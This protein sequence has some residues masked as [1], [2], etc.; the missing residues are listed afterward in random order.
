VQEREREWGVTVLEANGVL[1]GGDAWASATFPMRDATKSSVYRNEVTEAA[2]AA[3][4]EALEGIRCGRRPRAAAGPQRRGRE[5]PPMR[6]VD[7]TIDWTSDDT[8]TVLRKI[9]AAD[10]MPGV[11]DSVLGVDCMLHGAHVAPSWSPGGHAPGAAVSTCRGAILRATRDGG[12]WITH[13][14]R[15]E[16]AHGAAIKLPACEV[17]GEV[18]ARLPGHA[19]ASSGP[20]HPLRYE[21][22]GAVGIVHFAFHNG[23][24]SADDCDALHA[25]LAAARQR[26]TR[27]LVLAGGPDYWSNGL[28]LNR[29][30]ASAHPAD[31]S[32]DNI[33][34]MNRVV[35]AIVDVDDRLTIAAMQGSA[36]AGGVFLALAADR[37][38][39]RE[40]AVL[41]AHYRAM[42]N[43]YGSEYWTYLLPRR[44]GA[45]RAADLVASRLPITGA[46][47]ARIG[48]ADAAFGATPADFLQRTLAR[49]HALAASADVEA[50]LAAKRLRRAADEAVKPL[51]R[52][53]DEE[54]AR[55][56][57]NFRGFDPS[58][59]VA[60]HHFVCKLPKARTPSFLAR[61]RAP[62]PVLRARH[63]T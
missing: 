57:L 59:H 12:V 26:P 25:A 3:V 40:G 33:V 7:R 38:F 62:R 1:D 61:H 39:V 27:V 11:R 35:R 43:L 4:R 17:L 31:A 9:R 15:A 10:G 52:Y 51:D 32:W 54:L 56:K 34:A 42:G 53:A 6:Q 45:A 49:A 48:L 24:M 60:R 21:E 36:G 58:Y 20:P 50:M 55:M 41:N 46:G 29:I 2:L 14:K 23:A 63:E 8:A 5:R 22:R 18:A 44:V 47:A 16:A 13:M 28:D 37:V 30:E 19:D